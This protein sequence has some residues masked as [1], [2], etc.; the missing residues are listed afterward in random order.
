MITISISIQSAGKLH[1]QEVEGTHVELPYGIRGVAHKGV[2]S[3]SWVVSEPIFGSVIERG[4]TKKGAI[5]AAKKQ[6][7]K[8]G[9]VGFRRAMGKYYQNYLS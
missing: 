9:L 7:E 1:E 4:K 5:D 2:D 3:N 8:V 6:V